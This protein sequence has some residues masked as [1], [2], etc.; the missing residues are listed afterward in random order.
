MADEEKSGV[1]TRTMRRQRSRTS[2]GSKVEDS[3]GEAGGEKVSSFVQTKMH[4]SNESSIKV[5]VLD[6]SVLMHNIFLCLHSI[7]CPLQ[8]I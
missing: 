7:S 5:E 3:S 8:H 2:S 1:E 4:Q 6:S